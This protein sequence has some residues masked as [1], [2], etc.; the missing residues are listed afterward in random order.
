MRKLT[1][2]LSS[3]FI[4]GVTF[5]ANTCES[6]HIVLAF[7]ILKM[8]FKNNSSNMAPAGGQTHLTSIWKDSTVINDI[9]IFIVSF[10]SWAEFFEFVGI[11]IWTVFAVDGIVFGTSAVA[12]TG[13]M[14]RTATLIE[15]NGLGGRG[16][17]SLETH[18]RLDCCVTNMFSDILTFKIINRK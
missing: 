5:V 6:W 3:S 14:T 13:T 9:A 10:T 8:V 2:A 18:T 17:L 16:E 12:P 4:N 15:A 1:N 7:T 11:W